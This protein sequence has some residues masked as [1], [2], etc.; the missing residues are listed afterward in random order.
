MFRFPVLSLVLSAS[1]C[2]A[3]LAHAQGIVRE[4]QLEQLRGE[5]GDVG[6]RVKASLE[7]TSSSM[8]AMQT[9]TGDAQTEAA[10]A[11]LDS[12]EEETRVVLEQVK[13]NSPFMDAL[14]DAR[15]KV[16]T[17]LRKHERE[18]QS[19][20]RDARVARLT[21]ALGDLETQYVEIQG[22]E[23]TMTRLLSEHALLRREIQLNG[24]VGAVE[25]FVADLGQLTA[26]LQ[27]MTDVLAEVSA[28]TIDTSDGPAIAQD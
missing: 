25:K 20:A 16:V 8:Q 14:D 6:S 1:L 10:Y 17:I 7:A 24:E 13:L 23:K 12:I 28:T 11:L 19:S 22:V 9:Y 18:P 26:D 5:L 4:D 15:A 2:A 3:S 27:S 21:V